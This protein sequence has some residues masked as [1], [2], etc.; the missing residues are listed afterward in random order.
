MKHEA[1]SERVT[2]S[3]ITRGGITLHEMGTKG[4]SVRIFRCHGIRESQEMRWKACWRLCV[5]LGEW[6]TALAGMYGHGNQRR[7]CG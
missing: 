5:V 1:R 6:T 2:Y 7:V 4:E 3:I